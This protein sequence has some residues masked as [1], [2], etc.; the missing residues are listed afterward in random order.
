MVLAV[1]RGVAAEQCISLA[2][3]HER[4]LATPMAPELGLFLVRVLRWLC[5]PLRRR[6][7][8]ALLVLFVGG[9]CS[10]DASWCRQWA[11]RRAC[12]T[13]ARCPARRATR[14]AAHHTLR[15]QQDE[16][17][18]DS[19][20]ARFGELHGHVTFEPF[21][22]AAEQFKHDILYPHI[23]GVLRCLC[24]SACLCL[25]VCV[26]P[27]HLCSA[28]LAVSH[29]RVC[30]CVSRARVCVS[31]AYAAVMFDGQDTRHT[32]SHASHRAGRA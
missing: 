10:P 20:N 9:G 7:R 23:A 1:M 5:G 26:A 4:D 14:R 30:V 3:D 24:V 13:P 16:T 21:R 2:L 27:R 6:T 28:A 25:G 11:S 18:Y 31:P 8:C 29:V 15:A 22:R 19:Y 17:F 12:T 32:T